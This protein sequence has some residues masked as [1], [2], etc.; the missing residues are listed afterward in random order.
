MDCFGSVATSTSVR[1][2]TDGIANGIVAASSPP[3]ILSSVDGTSG[4]V[5]GV[6]NTK[7]GSKT[8]FDRMSDFLI[9]AD[10]VT[11]RPFFDDREGPA[12]DAAFFLTACWRISTA[13][14]R[15]LGYIVAIKIKKSVQFRNKQK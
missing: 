6:D 13:D 5:V 8:D 2:S 15:I 7:T 4:S 11:T 3:A 10:G 1:T 12:L 9:G 14:T